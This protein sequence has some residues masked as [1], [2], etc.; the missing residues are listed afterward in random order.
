MSNLKAVIL[1]AGQGTRMK[2]KVPKVLHKILDKTLLDYSIEAAFQAGV[3]EICVVVGHKSELVK[4]SINKKVT[5]ILQKEQLGTGHAVMQAKDFIGTSGEVLILFGDTPL[6]TGKTLKQLVSYHKDNNNTVTVLSTLIDNPAGY[7]RIIRDEKKQFLKSVEHKD[8]TNQEKLVKEINSG[9]Y[10]YESEALYYSLEVLTNDNVQ[11]EYYLPDTLKSIKNDGKTVDAMLIEDHTEVLGV[12]SRVQLAQAQ[13][14][15]QTRINTYWMEQGVTIIN[16]N[17]TYISKDVI[18]DKDVTIYPNTFI[19][20]N[21]TINEDS[22]IGPNTKICS[23]NIGENTTIK[24]S[25]ILNSRIGCQTKVGPFAYIRPN[26][27]IGDRVKI[28]DFVEIKNAT[29]GNDTKVSHLT[30]I[31]D[32]DIGERVNFGCG[33]VVVNYDGKKKH[34][35][36]VK[37]DAFIGCNTNLISPV[38]VGHNAYTGAGSTINKNVPSY[39]LAIARARQINKEEWVKKQNK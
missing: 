13:M 30:Y 37:D 3:E 11:R 36:T 22:I 23:S 4:N 12:N 1:A 29:I 10:I 39:A 15:M 24:Q 34:R 14:I 20:G 21:S 16:P 9:M 32:A 2:S 18:L 25:V 17:Q 38:N 28:G 5:Y 35:T 33:T 19:E 31:G 8:A 26:S 6:I 7:G 27:T